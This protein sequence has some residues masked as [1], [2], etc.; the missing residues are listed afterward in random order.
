MKKRL[1]TSQ[2]NA[3]G[4]V[5]GATMVQDAVTHLDRSPHPSVYPSIL[6]SVC[7]SVHPSVQAA[8]QI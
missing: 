7:L 2:G 1:S 3:L 5:G 6:L 8:A 4:Q